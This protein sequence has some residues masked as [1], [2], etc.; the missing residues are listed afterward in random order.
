MPKPA[1]S[2][3]NWVSTAP[4]PAGVFLFLLGL[5]SG[6]VS[7]LLTNPRMGL[8]SHL[9]GVMNGLFLLALG[10]VWGRLRLTARWS[11]ALFWL[12]LYGTYA[13]W[14][15]TLFAAVVGA[16]SLTPIAGAGHRAAAWQE[17]LVSLGLYSLS[18][19]MLAVRVIALVGLRPGA[20][21]EENGA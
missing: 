18:A 2:V 11:G 1:C 14:A 15:T 6:L 4:S 20:A 16:G 13:N 8:S 7:G 5:I 3:R 10:P 21:P 9:E 12:A 19:A 17:H